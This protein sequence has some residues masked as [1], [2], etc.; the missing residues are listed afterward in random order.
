MPAA[1]ARGDCVLQAADVHIVEILPP[2]LPDA[3]ERRRVHQ[4]FAAGGG[5]AKVIGVA[6]VAVERCSGRLLA[7]ARREKTTTSCPRATSACA[8]ARPR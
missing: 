2:A 7:L 8:T 1:F 3:D 6:D 4:T 5:A